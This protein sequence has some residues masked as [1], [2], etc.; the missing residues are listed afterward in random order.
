MS[1]F[2]KNCDILLLQEHWLF[3]YQLP[4]LNEINTNI[5][6][7]GKGVDLRNPLPPIQMP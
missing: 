5:T 4:F 1:F 7:V 6:A 3:Q 2:L